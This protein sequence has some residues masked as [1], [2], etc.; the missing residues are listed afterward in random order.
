MDIGELHPLLC[1]WLHVVSAMVWIGHIWSLVFAQPMHRPPTDTW[2]R[3]WAGATWLTGVSLLILVYYAGG[4][5]T[6]PSSVWGVAMLMAWFM[7]S[8]VG[9]VLFG[10]RGCGRCPAWVC[11]RRTRR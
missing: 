4:A 5:L 2:S 10:R 1:R 9:G 7:A 8:S 3:A 11:W 6:T